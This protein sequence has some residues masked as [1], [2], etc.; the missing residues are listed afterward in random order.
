MAQKI[1]PQSAFNSA[2]EKFKEVI[3]HIRI[4]EDEVEVVVMI[5]AISFAEYF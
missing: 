5:K 1:L 2:W 4:A 3:Q